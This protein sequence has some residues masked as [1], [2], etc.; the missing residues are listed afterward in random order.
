[1]TGMKQVVVIMLAVGLMLGGWAVMALAQS[2]P[3]PRY[4]ADD[5]W[6]GATKP[7]S[8]SNYQGGEYTSYPPDPNYSNAAKSSHWMHM[9]SQADHTV[10]GKITELDLAKGT[11]TLDSGEQFT[12]S[13]D[14]EY[15]SLPMLGQAVEVTFVE[16]NGQKVVHQID[17]DDT[18][19][20]S[21]SS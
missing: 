4:P 9:G 12:L 10:T 8:M 18:G 17:P 6:T 7:G 2:A 1:M 21:H 3:A 13:Q 14:F 20:S 15:T 11:M 19:R 16:Q 5:S